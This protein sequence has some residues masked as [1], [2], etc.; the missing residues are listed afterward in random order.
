MTATRV[1]SAFVEMTGS[2][3]VVLLLHPVGASAR[4][5]DAI[6]P[7]LAERFRV[8]AVDLRGHGSCPRPSRPFDLT[9][10]ARDVRAVADWIS[11]HDP[12]A[13]VGLSLGGMVAQVAALEEPSRISA[14]V[15]ADTHFEISEVSSGVFAS[16]AANA[17]RGGMEAVVGPSL[18]RWF[19]ARAFRESPELID[20]VRSW[21]LEGDAV[22]HAW[23]WRALVTLDVAD[24]LKEILVPV[25]VV[26]GSEDVATTPDNAR[27]HAELL[28]NA[29]L[30][31]IERAG[32]L[33]ALERPREFVNVVLAFLERAQPGTP[34][35]SSSATVGG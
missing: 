26:V 12:V 30:A 6:V 18:E 1:G 24:R 19:S 11:P 20:T 22:A 13:L 27:R 21:L 17:E 15:L 9:D 31:T 14:M 4:F 7:T 2:G 10:L 3:P 16:R 28:P 5:W 32:H 8:A 34:P 33:S 23:T 25:L 29:Q 35:S